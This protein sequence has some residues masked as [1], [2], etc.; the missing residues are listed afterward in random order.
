[1]SSL[2]KQSRAMSFAETMT[3]VV[4]GFV[5]SVAIQLAI[6]PLFGIRLA[7]ST[8]LAIGAAFTMMSVVRGYLLRRLFERLRL[9]GLRSETAALKRAATSIG[10]WA[11]QLP[12]R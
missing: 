6:F 1:M 11:Y 3:N 8:N 12:M 4:V 7:V 10:M 2:S 9:H 5:A